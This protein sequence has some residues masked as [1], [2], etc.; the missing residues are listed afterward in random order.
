MGGPDL[1]AR[2]CLR[3]CP[4]FPLNRQPGVHRLHPDHAGLHAPHRLQ[5]MLQYR[6][7]KYRSPVQL[8]RFEA[9][10]YTPSMLAELFTILCRYQTSL[11]LWVIDEWITENGH[12]YWE[13]WL[14]SL[15]LIAQKKQLGLIITLEMSLKKA[16]SILYTTNF[17][18]LLYLTPLKT[19][20]RK[21]RFRLRMYNNSPSHK[22]Y[23]RQLELGPL[24]RERKLLVSSQPKASGS[25]G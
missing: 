2:L 3:L 11:G 16:V 4:L 14:N 5:K 10:Y 13:Y 25:G 22:V 7:P 1:H 6:V 24:F 12:A 8:G 17:P 23:D 18:Y 9:L 20:N 19:K 21:K 15:S